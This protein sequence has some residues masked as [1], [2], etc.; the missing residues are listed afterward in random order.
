[1]L[2]LPEPALYGAVIYHQLHCD[3]KCI[4]I[5]HTGLN[6]HS[7]PIFIKAVKLTFRLIKHKGTLNIQMAYASHKLYMHALEYYLVVL[8]RRRKLPFCYQ[9]KL[10]QCCQ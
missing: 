10:Y 1:M 5:N 6:T 8:Y 9:C 7:A 3:I 4:H 2:E